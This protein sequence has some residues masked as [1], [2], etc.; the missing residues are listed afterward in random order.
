MLAN[1]GISEPSAQYDFHEGVTK[2]AKSVVV[3]TQPG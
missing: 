3:Y 2:M 1:Q